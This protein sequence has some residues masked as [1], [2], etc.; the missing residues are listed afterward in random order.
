MQMLP[1]NKT[2]EGRTDYPTTDQVHA[3]YATS[4]KNILLRTARMQTEYRGEIFTTRT[5]INK[6]I[7]FNKLSQIDL[8]QS[9]KSTFKNLNPLIEEI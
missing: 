4:S 7:Y 9:N 2:D 3:N 6:L 5:L 1:Q 8:V